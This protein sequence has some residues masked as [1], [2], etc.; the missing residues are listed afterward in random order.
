ME[1]DKIWC[2]ALLA[3]AVLAGCSRGASDEEAK[4]EGDKQEVAAN[5]EKGP[6]HAVRNFLEAVR[7]G[8]DT[9][10]SKLL[11][12]VARREIAREKL[13]IAPPGSDTASYKVGKVEQESDELAQVASTWSDIGDDGREQTSS[14]V[15]R[16][17]KES[18]GWRIYGMST[19]V[20]DDKPPIFLNFEKPKE[21]IR[22][23]QEADDELARR[24]EMETDDVPE[25]DESR[26]PPRTAR[27]KG[28]SKNR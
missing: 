2:S 5:Q 3:L 19:K 12:N 21:M 9:T 16:L 15:W 7:V 13:D 20:F 11:T 1:R 17:R 6:G 18:K 14:I 27:K 4:A 8:N 23:Q 10:A 22:K 25:N 26:E 24:V 28:R